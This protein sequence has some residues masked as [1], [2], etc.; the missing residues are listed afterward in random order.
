MIRYF[1]NYVCYH[2]KNKKGCGSSKLYFSDIKPIC[3]QIIHRGHAED[4][5]IDIKSLMLMEN[6]AN[7][8]IFFSPNY[9]LVIGCQYHT[10]SLAWHQGRQP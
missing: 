3:L 8:L 7:T 6:R 2:F 1:Y 10:W 9:W 5:L 4:T